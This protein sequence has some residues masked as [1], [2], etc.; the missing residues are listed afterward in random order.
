MDKSKTGA[1]HRL[2]KTKSLNR[3]TSVVDLSLL[4]DLAF[5]LQLILNVAVSLAVS[6]AVVCPGL[7]SV[8]VCSSQLF[9]G[10]LA[11]RVTSN[12]PIAT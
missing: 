6:L 5:K 9:Y 3:I 12:I 1:H 11:S 8:C 7:Q 2:S 10:C 4:R